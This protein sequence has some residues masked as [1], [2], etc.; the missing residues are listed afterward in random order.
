MVK[1]ADSYERQVCRETSGQELSVEGLSR[2]AIV[3]IEDARQALKYSVVNE[4]NLTRT[5][6]LPSRHLSMLAQIKS[7][8]EDIWSSL[9]SSGSKVEISN[10]E[11]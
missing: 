6:M 8:D 10:L 4:E 7:S 11:R 2:R 5:L 9:A 3:S 1:L